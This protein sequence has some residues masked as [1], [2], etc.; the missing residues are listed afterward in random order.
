MNIDDN[1]NFGSGYNEDFIIWI[2]TKAPNNIVYFIKYGDK[3]DDI[4]WRLYWSLLITIWRL[5]NE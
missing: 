5:N 2:N 4:T 1:W 3:E